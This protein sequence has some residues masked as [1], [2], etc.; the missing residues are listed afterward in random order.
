MAHQGCA[1]RGGPGSPAW[2]LGV[3]KP[4]QKPIL[5]RIIAAGARGVWT[6]ELCRAGGY[7]NPASLPGVLK[8]IGGR[9]R[10]TGHRPLWNGGPRD[11]Q[12]QLLSVRDETAGQLFAKVLKANH[13]D[14]AQQ[15]GMD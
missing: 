14:L 2:I 13:P 4:N 3:L 8:A 6:T 10:A 12:G 7:H 5:G 11:A 9:F 1:N 15:C